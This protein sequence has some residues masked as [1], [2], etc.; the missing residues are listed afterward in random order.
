LPQLQST[1]TTTATTTAAA[2]TTT[3][4]LPLHSFAII[5]IYFAVD[6]IT[7]VVSIDFLV[8]ISVHIAV[9]FLPPQGNNNNNN[10]P[11]T[12]FLCH[13]CHLLCC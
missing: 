1:A 7:G 12:S 9:Y 5:A 2:T 13:Y 4:D 6:I 10:R 8:D 11:T 3:T